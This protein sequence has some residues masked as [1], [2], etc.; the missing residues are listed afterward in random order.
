MT[1]TVLTIAIPT[2]NRA[3]YLD[4]CLGNIVSQLGERR[5]MVELVVSDNASADHTKDIVQ[6]YID[7][8]YSIKYIK[9][10]EN[11]GA[12][13]NVAQC[14]N[15]A[16]G[17]YVVTFGDDDVFVTGA[18]ELLVD[19]L[20][21]KEVGIVYM[22]NYAL[23]SMQFDDRAVT[24]STVPVTV[25]SNTKE[26]VKRVS[27]FTTF[28]SGNIVNRKALQQVDLAEYQGSSLG[29]VPLVLKAM[30]S[31]PENVIVEEPLVAM[32]TENTGGYSLFRTFATN[33]M[34]ILD[35]AFRSER[36]KE[37][38]SIIIKDLLKTFYPVW[39]YRLKTRNNFQSEEDVYGIMH[40]L[41]KEYKAFWLYNYPL[42]RLSGTPAKLYYKGVKAI[43]SFTPKKR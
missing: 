30:T 15:S 3:A 1:E 36:E 14:Y 38:K 32:Q 35:K 8:G 11:K 19:F 6:K 24:P 28:L 37:Y 43:N 33:Y 13:F 21:S 10:A 22:K 20:K 17:K 27:Y 5:D 12:D 2:Y 41:F 40:P 29:H 7:A 26:F 23:T 18:I 42:I 31:F 4:R 9:N 34:K 16:S 39:I 25:F